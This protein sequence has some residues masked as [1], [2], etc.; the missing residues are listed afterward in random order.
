MV[1]PQLV[2]GGR[3]LR[4]GAWVVLAANA[5]L[6]VFCLAF[7]AVELTRGPRAL[8][9]WLVLLVPISLIVWIGG[10]F[11]A[12]LN[13]R[14]LHPS[15]EPPP[16]D[17]WGRPVLRIPELP[18][19]RGY[20][21]LAVACVVLAM[22]GVPEATKGQPDIPGP[23]CPYPLTGDHGRLHECVSEQEYRRVRAATHRLFLG[24]AAA[25]CAFEAGLAVYIL[26]RP[27]TDDHA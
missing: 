23:G 14:Q 21:L 26:R 1:V 5:P 16:L 6:G 8:T 13:Y 4:P 25:V 17:K 3:N 15:T 24:G 11:L 18:V 20:L 27:E 7:V 10:G 12:S 2:P 19:A 22:T 9:L